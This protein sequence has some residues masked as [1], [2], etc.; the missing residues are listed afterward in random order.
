MYNACDRWNGLDGD[1]FAAVLGRMFALLVVVQWPSRIQLFVTL[2]TAACEA[3]ANR[4]YWLAR[5]D[6]YH[7]S[8]LFSM[9]S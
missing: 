6:L 9:D 2:W 5:P 3:S 8:T 1:S 7:V 4:L